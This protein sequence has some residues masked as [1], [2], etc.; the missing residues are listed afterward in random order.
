MCTILNKQETEV[1]F[2]MELVDAT[3]GYN[4]QIAHISCG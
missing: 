2:E 3:N 1:T 4:A